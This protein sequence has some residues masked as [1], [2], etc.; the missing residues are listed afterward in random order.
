MITQLSPPE[1]RVTGEERQ[2]WQ[3]ALE[4]DFWTAVH[5]MPANVRH[6][7]QDEIQKVSQCVD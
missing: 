2:A 4:S 3:A 5:H 7:M 6:D 1:D